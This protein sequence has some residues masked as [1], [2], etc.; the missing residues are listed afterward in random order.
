MSHEELREQASAY[1]LGALDGDDRQRFEAHLAGC[2]ECQA[3]VRSFRPVVDA[4]A[5]SVDARE[6]SA[7]LRARVVGAVTRG[8]TRTTEIPTAMGRSRS[9][10][11]IPWV[12]ATAAT[13]ALAAL[14]PYTAQLRNRTRELAA[15]VRDLSA[16]LADSD[17]QLLV[18]RNNVSLLL[19]PDVRRVDLRGQASAPQAGGRAYFSRT[20]GVYFVATDLPSI[21]ADKAYQLWF[22]LPG[23]ANPVSAAVFS[24]DAGGRAELI[25]NVPAGMTDPSVL[26]VTLEPAG[27]SPQPT[28]TPFLVGNV[29]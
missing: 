15:V 8:Q 17:R 23:G 6:P 3:E 19:A 14:T 1:V 27:G 18:A 5:R 20:R 12:L 29:N 2:A 26:A 7:D 13:I 10:T 16:R 22:V 4:L 28:T 25:A 11:V 24:A 9:S 21:A